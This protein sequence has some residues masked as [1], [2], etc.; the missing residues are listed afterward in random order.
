[1]AEAIE[2]F[3]QKLEQYQGDAVAL[4][5]YAGHGLQINNVNYLVP[6][7]TRINNVRDIKRNTVPLINITQILEDVES[8][9]NIIIL[10]ACRNN[11]FGNIGNQSSNS[12]WSKIEVKRIANAYRGISDKAQ[13]LIVAYATAPG[14][15]AA[16]NA[17]N[18]KNGLFT[19]HLLENIDQQGM[20]ISELFIKVRTGVK[21]ES[22]GSQI[23][24]VDSVIT[25]LDASSI[26]LT[27]LE[28]F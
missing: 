2:R 16:D 6:V 10:D 23:S 13:G 15:V 8:R 22:G 27:R 5:Y 11:P 18:G 1:M 19:S 24:L 7:D 3:E 28:V 9:F 4:F 26:V 14:D 12:G 17:I 20:S 25:G 21:S